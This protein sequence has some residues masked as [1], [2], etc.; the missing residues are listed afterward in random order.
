MSLTLIYLTVLSTGR[1]LRCH[2]PGRLSM[3][4]W[5]RGAPTHSDGTA[6]RGTDAFSRQRANARCWLVGLSLTIA[7]I[8]A[9]SR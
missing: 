8:G 2:G 7:F 5:E 3:E 9:E 1:A 6:D 4:R